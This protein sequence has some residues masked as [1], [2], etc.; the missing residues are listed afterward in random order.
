LADN[1][2]YV[3]ENATVVFHPKIN[4]TSTDATNYWIN[5]S[6]NEI[7]NTVNDFSFGGSGLNITLRYTDQNGTEETSGEVNPL[8]Q[9][10]FW[11]TYGENET[12]R[13][14]ITVGNIQ[15]GNNTWDGSL[16]IE[17]TNATSDFSFDV[18]LPHQN[19]TTQNRILLP[20]EMS[21]TQGS[22]SKTMNAS[23]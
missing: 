16:M 15:P 14:D 8:A 22:I 23:R 11:I 12:R 18:E 19:S 2:Q 6:V 1:F 20:L 13:I 17:M 5:I 10:K 4:N 7:R 3:N 9:N 21:Y